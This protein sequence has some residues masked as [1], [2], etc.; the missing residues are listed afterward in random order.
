[1]TEKQYLDR[2]F[3]TLWDWAEQHCSGLLGGSPVLRPEFADRN[4]L[5]PPDGAH[6]D[7]IHAAIAQK[8]RH[9]W[10]RS[11]RSSQALAQSVF[12]AITA[13]NRLDI[14]QG[15]AAE[16]GCPAFFTDSEDWCLEMECAI[17]DNNTMKE[18]GKGRTSIDVLLDGPERRVAVE[19]KFTEVEFG[20]CSRTET[21]ICPQ[22]AL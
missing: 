21:Q 14:L 5:V 19:C 11:L 12:G 16:C 3:R 20:R 18:K 15:I 1:M 17:D 7:A 13:F 10:F 2:V 22:G 8:Q 9:R 6:A 4:V